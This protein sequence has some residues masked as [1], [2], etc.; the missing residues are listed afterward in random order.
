KQWPASPRSPPSRSS[1]ADRF[2]GSTG[3][4][5]GPRYDDGLRADGPLY[6]WRRMGRPVAPRARDRDD[7]RRGHSGSS[8]HGRYSRPDAMMA[9]SFSLSAA[10]PQ[11]T[12]PMIAR[13][14][15]TCRKK[16]DQSDGNGHR[17]R[18]QGHGQHALPR[19]IKNIADMP[20]R[21]QT[22]QA[23]FAQ[24]MGTQ[25]VSAQKNEGNGP[26]IAHDLGGNGRGKG[27]AADDPGQHQGDTQME[28][29]EGRAGTRRPAGEA[30]GNRGRSPGHAANAMGKVPGRSPEPD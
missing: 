20:L 27:T 16:A 24:H 17:N 21:R 18:A 7:A 28:P 6:R 30:D 26:R 10:P 14:E 23:G 25:P 22:V 4:C 11:F 15:K 19:V 5:R 12:A 8:P 13:D 1:T 2:P 9:A 29:D 3:R